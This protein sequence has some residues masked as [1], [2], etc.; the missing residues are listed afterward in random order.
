MPFCQLIADIISVS[1]WGKTSLMGEKS[2]DQHGPFFSQMQNW[3][4]V[5]YK[6]FKICL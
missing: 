4:P 5:L 6:G 2:T 3:W 1:E